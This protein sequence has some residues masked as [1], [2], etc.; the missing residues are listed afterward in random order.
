M[1]RVLSQDTFSARPASAPAYIYNADPQ[2][3]YAVRPDL[4][5]DC[6][7]GPDR[8][9][10]YNDGLRVVLKVI[11]LAVLRYG[12]TARRDL[13]YLEDVPFSRFAAD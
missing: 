6:T 5:P 2:P 11:L 1:S 7:A 12:C 10:V 13:Y 9:N 4:Q 3:D 8:K